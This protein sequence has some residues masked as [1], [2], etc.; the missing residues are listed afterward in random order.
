MRRLAIIKQADKKGLVLQ[1]T[2]AKKIMNMCCCCGCC[3]Q[4]L[5]T[6]K[7]HPKPAEMVSSPFIA[8]ADPE[9]CKACGVCEDRCQMDA[10]TYD[11]EE[12]VVLNLDR[13]IGCGLCVSTCP[14]EV[15]GDGAQ[16]RG[17]PGP[18]AQE[19]HGCLV[20]DRAGQGQAK[21]CQARGVEPQV[22]RWTGS[23]PTASLS[24]FGF[25]SRRAAVA[26]AG[27]AMIFSVQRCQLPL[28]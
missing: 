12:K 20:E 19:Q 8:Q 5:K 18:G 10:I 16:A 11:D 17:S 26:E 13:C 1:P 9:T 27:R 28:K 24:V 23:W 2:N 22:Q 3:C 14:S 21:P 6:F 7:R 4:V 15:L 25:A